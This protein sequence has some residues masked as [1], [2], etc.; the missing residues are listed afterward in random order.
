MSTD[1]DD[2]I[3]VYAKPHLD[4]QDVR[5]LAASI[6]NCSQVNPPNEFTIPHTTVKPTES[7][8]SYF[9]SSDGSYFSSFSRR[10]QQTFSSEQDDQNNKDGGSGKAKCIECHH[11]EV[12]SFLV[13]DAYSIEKLAAEAEGK[14]G[15]T[16]ELEGAGIARVDVYCQSGSVITCRLIQTNGADDPAADGDNGVKKNS[17]SISSRGSSFMQIL[18]TPRKGNVTKNISTDLSGGTQLR[19]IIRRKCTLEGLKRIL[20]DP[21]KL[22][23]IDS[24]TMEDDNTDDDDDD[25]DA[26]QSSTVSKKLL[27]RKQQ[28]LSASKKKSYKSLFS[29]KQ[30]VCLQKQQIKY[31]KRIMRDEK[32]RQHVGNAILAAGMEGGCE[33]M[34]LTPFKSMSLE[35]KDNKNATTDQ[36]IESELSSS[37]IISHTPGSE[38]YHCQKAIQD[39]IEVAD[40]GLAILMGEAQRLE[41]MMETIKKEKGLDD[42]ENGKESSLG[43]GNKHSKSVG[44]GYDTDLSFSTFQ[45]TDRDVGSDDDDDDESS[46]SEDSMD[47]QQRQAVKARKMQGCDVEYSFPNE[48]HDELEAALMN[49]QDEEDDDDDDDDDDSSSSDCSDDE[50]RDV[51]ESRRRGR[52]RS[53]P[54]NNGTSGGSGGKQPRS[55]EISPIIA[56]PTNGEGCIILREDG[57]FSMIGKSTIPHMLEKELFRKNGPLPDKIFLG[58]K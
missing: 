12:V 50:S 39:K 58:S 6:P 57:T 37:S 45:S 16:S 21:P 46:D 15:S 44:G 51:E 56:I 27:Q 48:L 32:V 20:E 36:M 13:S 31:E 4:P 23:E 52:G 42:K 8:S 22:P 54:K 18:P 41:K 34:Y 35:E 5:S 28:R 43:S 40:M 38:A 29:N 2:E 47:S 24:V 55:E 30:Q 14:H 19:R 1:N 49:E 10:L 9:S 53:P 26:S 3:T 7:S 33:A 25:D 11:H 17:E